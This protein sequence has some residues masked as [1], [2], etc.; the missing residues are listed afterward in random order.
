MTDNSVIWLKTGACNALAD[1][2]YQDGF[3]SMD[4]DAIDAPVFLPTGHAIR[5]EYISAATGLP[6]LS[7]QGGLIPRTGEFQ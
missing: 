2:R 6:V 5:N 3:F 4:L 1:V 7:L